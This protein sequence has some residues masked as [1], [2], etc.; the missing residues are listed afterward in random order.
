MT[1]AEFAAM[2]ELGW[3]KKAKLLGSMGENA[4][5]AVALDLAKG[6]SLPQAAKSGAGMAILPLAGKIPGGPVARTLGAGALMAAP[7]VVEGG[8]AEDIAKSMTF[9]T[10]MHGLMTEAPKAW[11]AHK[12]KL[13]EV[14]MPSVQ[15]LV[16][17]VEHVRVST[18]AIR[19]TSPKEAAAID[20]EPDYRKKIALIQQWGESGAKPN[21]SPDTSNPVNLFTGEVVAPK[22]PVRTVLSPEQLGTPQDL[23][24]AMQGA[25]RPPTAPDLTAPKTQINEANAVPEVQKPLQKSTSVEESIQPVPKAETTVP[26]KGAVSPSVEKPV[27]SETKQPWEMT[28]SEYVAS[29]TRLD[30]LGKRRDAAA[31]KI[32]GSQRWGEA[33]RFAGAKAGNRLDASDKARKVWAKQYDR[34]EA[35]HG[36]LVESA[37]REGRPVP[38][39]VL[40]DYPDLAAKYATKVEPTTSVV[41]TT[42]EKPKGT[43]LER[44]R[45]KRETRKQ[46][47]QRGIDERMAQ[48]VKDV[49]DDGGPRYVAPQIEAMGRLIK[50]GQYL[51]RA[52]LVMTDLNKWETRPT[53]A[54]KAAQGQAEVG[55]ETPEQAKQAA[56]KTAA[57]NVEEYL[58]DTE[59]KGQIAEPAAPMTF[60][61]E[62]DAEVWLR[63]NPVKGQVGR[64]EQSPKGFKVAFEPESGKPLPQ[65]REGTLARAAKM[66]EGFQEEVAPKFGSKEAA[67]AGRAYLKAKAAESKPTKFSPR[68]GQRGSLDLWDKKSWDAVVNIGIDNLRNYG[69][70]KLRW[71][72]HMIKDIGEPVREW[73]DDIWESI[74]E[75]RAALLAAQGATGNP[76]AAKKAIRENI[77]QATRGD[78]VPMTP[79]MLLKLSLT[80]EARGAKAGYRAG[81]LDAKASQEELLAYAKEQLPEGEYN[82]IARAAE[83][84]IKAKDA[85]KQRETII[86]SVNNMA[87]NYE[88]ASAIKEAIG[89]INEARRDKRLRPE[90]AKKLE[91]L[92]ENLA[93]STPKAK[94]IDAAMSVLHAEEYAEGST[95]SPISGVPKK[96]VDRA[97]EMLTRASNPNIRKLDTDTIRTITE[98]VKMLS[99]LSAT[100]NKLLFGARHRDALEAR[101]TA[102]KELKARQGEG[103]K[104]APGQYNPDARINRLMQIAGW[105]QLSRDTKAYILFG[106]NST[107]SELIFENPRKSTIEHVRRKQA[108]QDFIGEKFKEAG[109]DVGE[110]ATWSAGMDEAGAKKN[111]TTIDLPTA[112]DETGV[113]V[114]Q[115][116]LTKAEYVDLVAHILD[117]STKS[118]LL[119]NHSKGFRF[120]RSGRELAIKPTLQ[121][122]N[123]IMQQ[124]DPKVKAVAE[125]LREYMN[126]QGKK[127]INEAWVRIFG[128]ELAKTSDHW[129]RSRTGEY[130]IGETDPNADMNHWVQ[131]KLE[132]LGIFQA[133]TGSNAPIE[134]TDA[135]QHFQ[136]H[137]NKST[138]FAAKAEATHDAMRLLDS[139]EFR[140]AAREAFKNGDAIVRDLK[141]SIW[142]F[143]GTNE[144]QGKGSL[145]RLIKGLVVRG[146]KGALIY[147]PTIPLYQLAGYATMA[148]E[149]SPKYLL[150]ALTSNAAEAGAEIYQWSPDLR[151][152]ANGDYAMR[153]TPVVAPETLRTFYG[154]K[155][156]GE[157]IGMGL[158]GKA[159]NYTINKLWNAV[160][161]EGADKGL[162]GDDLMK[163]TADRTSRIVELTQATWDTNT[164][165]TLAREARTSGFAHA[166]MA[167]ASQRNK[168]GNM[169]VRAVTEYRHSERT[170][171]D[172][173]KMMAK[174]INPMIVDSLLVAGLST[175]VQT[176]VQ[177]AAG[178]PVDWDKTFKRFLRRMPENMAGNWLVLGDVAAT[179]AENIYSAVSH[180]SNVPPDLRGNI[181]SNALESGGKAIWHAAA[182]LSAGDSKMK[183]GPF[184]GTS[185]RNVELWRAAEQGAYAGGLTGLPTPAL[186]QIV[187]PL[188]EAPKNATAPLPPPLEKR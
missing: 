151:A 66:G 2:P 89:A 17:T 14:D 97:V 160:K 127:E 29:D 150:K 35:E 38:P 45:G 18:D 73:L 186:I 64:I 20:A 11:A 100:K 101:D 113:R 110:L 74:G 32:G 179:V 25:L 10:L 93:V 156:G 39:E 165:S 183:S 121:D 138:A 53:M 77:V 148:N 181:V 92:V 170:A 107:G 116:Q 99:H 8:N 104:K 180:E 23:A 60:S 169:V 105:D 166:V 178:Q 124:A 43:L 62:R 112:R 79:N 176:G 141:E 144:M 63:D 47:V 119:R 168:L 7:T 90:Y 143:Q 54:E 4:V 52:G 161:L 56:L 22:P 59:K 182:G 172:K 98:S 27:A 49:T 75:H 163:Y 36:K 133:R 48:I 147:K 188:I 134:I 85:A 1:V 16:N 55:P 88:H 136:G 146:T 130:R 171:G 164:T 175:A 58:T 80:H 76:T 13:Q 106:D 83:R 69:N 152:R 95:D 71:A 102:V 3:A 37:I 94:T 137:V 81:K 57:K 122:L 50:T 158:I 51:E 103:Y 86:E 96:V 167:F 5:K 131:Q 129:P 184:K 15:E 115:V 145:D 87:V 118:E 65:P 120:D 6:Q 139:H 19:R 34:L 30:E 142:D 159:D 128:T 61:S 117:S 31:M 28:R 114:A 135:F 12:A 70:S 132:D 173:A 41:E 24:A 154:V 67:D 111:L 149:I 33:R 21:V 140:Q 109:I 78:E 177:A 123:A 68:K 125:V 91:T 26:E 82:L 84:I 72:A 185:K 174:I 155:G 46:A 40:A 187:K 9:G 126:G 157:G 44:Q 162:T 108:A 153:L 42:T